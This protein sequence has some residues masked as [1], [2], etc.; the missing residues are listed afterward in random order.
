MAVRSVFKLVLKPGL[1]AASGELEP[2]PILRTYQG[3]MYCG[4]TMYPGCSRCHAV[5][6]L[7]LM[8][9]TTGQT[10]F[11]KGLSWGTVLPRTLQTHSAEPSSVPCQPPEIAIDITSFSLGPD[12]S[13]L[14]DK[15]SKD[16]QVWVLIAWQGKYWR[17]EWG[18]GFPCVKAQWIYSDAGEGIFSCASG[19]SHI[20]KWFP[21]HP[22]GR[23]NRNSQ[24]A[25]I[26]VCFWLL[27]AFWTSCLSY[28]YI[29]LAT[30][31]A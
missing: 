7:V 2:V 28:I 4:T 26:L 15:C 20:P 24:V 22:G 27:R 19:C 1:R 11:C 14:L 5:S 9:L 16:C 17:G 10:G 21:L 29:S 6:P 25:F 13:Y 18:L 23:S 31:L 12:L 8:L 30:C 3:H